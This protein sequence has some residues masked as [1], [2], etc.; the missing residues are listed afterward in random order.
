MSPIDLEE[1]PLRKRV[2]LVVASVAELFN[3][4][5]VLADPSHHLSN[6]EWAQEVLASMTVDLR[7][8]VAY[9]GQNFDEWLEIADIT[10][11][12]YPTDIS[13]SAF[14]KRV[15][16]LPSEQLVDI[17][18]HGLGHNELPEY[19]QTEPSD[20][21]I[22]A[23]RLAA[24]ENPLGF[25]TRLL[26]VLQ[27]YWIEVFAAE[28]EKRRPLVEQR[29]TLEATRLD[30]MTPVQWLT[31]LH[32]RIS[33]EQQNETLIFHKSQDLRFQLHDLQRIVC[34][35][36]SFTAPHLMVGYARKELTIYINVP[37]TI[38]TPERVPPGLLLVAQALSDET[39]LRIFRSVL[40]RPHY[41]QELAI[42]MKLSE[43]TVSRH[44]KILKAAKLVNSHKEGPVVLYSGTLQPVDQFPALIREFLRG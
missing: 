24:E 14:L 36:S 12:V 33:Y 34:I 2:Q 29:R 40:R 22:L 11:L 1:D 43:P 21:G 4:L 3:S 25:V 27:R 39:R 30:N 38:A 19:S 44:L 13:I 31:T 18:L 28:W 35:P 41:T 20:P 6:Q 15:A 7:E 42:A 8:E 5:H 10:N 16:D 32:N 9:F 17:A 26:N 23:A 37:L